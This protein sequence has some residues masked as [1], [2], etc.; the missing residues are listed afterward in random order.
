MAIH[1]EAQLHHYVKN[2]KNFAQ[3]VQTQFASLHLTASKLRN[4]D[5]SYKRVDNLRFFRYKFHGN[6]HNYDSVLSNFFYHQRTSFQCSYFITDLNFSVETSLSGNLDDNNYYANTNRACFHH[7]PHGR[8]SF[9][10][11]STLWSGANILC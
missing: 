11:V 5:N 4:L 9:I 2:R 6:Y 1:D 7:I 10:V 3:V 8:D